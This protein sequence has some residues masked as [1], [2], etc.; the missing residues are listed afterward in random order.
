MTSH[1]TYGLDLSHLFAFVLIYLK[2]R[3]KYSQIFFIFCHFLFLDL[4]PFPIRICYMFVFALYSGRYYN[5]E[6]P[7]IYALFDA[8]TGKIFLLAKRV[9]TWLTQERLVLIHIFVELKTFRIKNTSPTAKVLLTVIPFVMMLVN[10]FN[11]KG[12]KSL[13]DW[14]FVSENGRLPFIT[15]GYNV[16]QHNEIEKK[17]DTVADVAPSIDQHKT[18]PSGDKIV[19]L[20]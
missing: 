14:T 2:D 1:V 7:R 4:F 13:M 16:P 20:G 12:V 15:L 17:S 10:I 5:A 8:P 19:T 6:N 18:S 11:Y 3:F 9:I